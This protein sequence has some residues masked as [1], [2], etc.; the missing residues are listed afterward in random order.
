MDLSS[1][2]QVALG[3]TELEDEVVVLLS[4]QLKLFVPC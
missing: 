4:N 3:D 1:A 2:K